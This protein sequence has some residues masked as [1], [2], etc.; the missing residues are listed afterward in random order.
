M[1]GGSGGKGRWHFLFACFALAP[2]R[3]SGLLRRPRVEPPTPLVVSTL[4]GRRLPSVAGQEEF[5]RPRVRVAA[6]VLS[7][8][9][10]SLAW[11]PVRGAT[12]RLG[13]SSNN[14]C[15]CG[16]LG[17]GGGG[18]WGTRERALDV[19]VAVWPPGAAAACVFMQRQFV[20]PWT[21]RRWVQRLRPSGSASSR[22]Q[23]RLGLLRQSHACYSQLP[24]RAIGYCAAA[25]NGA[26]AQ[27]LC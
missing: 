9:A 7:A 24:R 12:V 13:T 16:P 22:Q 26:P 17:S 1:A 25:A 19:F 27:L 15:G 23:R 18:G 14:C 8:P 10:R 11:G 3:R 6:V 2:I 21:W 20:N 5:V 4:Q